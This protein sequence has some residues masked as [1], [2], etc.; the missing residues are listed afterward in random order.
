MA[1]DYAAL[2]HKYLEE[3]DTLSDAEFGRLCRALL[4]YS[5]DGKE[6]QLQGAEKVVWKRVK[7]QEDRFKDSYKELSDS[8][9]EAGKKGAAKRW[10]SIANDSKAMASYGKA[11]ANDVVAIADPLPP[12]PPC[13]SPSSPP[14]HPPISNLSPNPPIIPPSPDDDTH[15]RRR[16]AT[17]TNPQIA[18]VFTAYS[19]KIESKSPMTEKIRDELL[20]L[21]E[22]VGPEVC[23]RAMDEAVEAGA[24]S[25]RYVRKVLENKREQGVRSIGDWDAVEK[26]RVAGKPGKY[27]AQDFQPTPERIRKNAER[28]DAFLAEQGGKDGET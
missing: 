20:A 21:L 18:V 7:M 27:T 28:L 26:K 13:P 16:V 23:V 14:P 8:R 22:A 9:R 24:I 17:P 5:M 25:W 11:I 3:M 1:R 19:E 4:Q 6:G 12:C 15:A 10:H 2:P